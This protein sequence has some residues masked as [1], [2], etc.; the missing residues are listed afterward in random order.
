MNKV[1]AFLAKVERLLEGFFLDDEKARAVSV[2]N[3]YHQVW[4]AAEEIDP[5]CWMNNLYYEDDG[6]Q[7]AIITSQGKLFRTDITITNGTVALGEWVEVKIDFPPVAQNRTTIK[8]QADGR[9][10]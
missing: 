7:F 6:Q 10:R 9:V 8:R 1:Q 4:E 5:Y 2:E 3:I